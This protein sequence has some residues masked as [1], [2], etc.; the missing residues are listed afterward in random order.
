MTRN[1]KK[2]ISDLKDYLPIYYFACSFQIY[3]FKL[4]FF[5]YLTCGF[6]ATETFQAKIWRYIFLIIGQNKVT[7]GKSDKPLFKRRVKQIN[8]L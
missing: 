7:R 5:F 2:D 6:L 8:V 4:W 1:S 3:F